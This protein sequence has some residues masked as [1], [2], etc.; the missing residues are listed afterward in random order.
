MYFKLSWFCDFFL[1]KLLKINV[2][3]VVYWVLKMKKKIINKILKILE[4]RYK[5]DLFNINM[6]CGL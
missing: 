1:Y 5:K 6:L 4:I 2:K 3:N